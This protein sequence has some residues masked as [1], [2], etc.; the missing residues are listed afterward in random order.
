M[1]ASSVSSSSPNPRKRSYHDADGS[2]GSHTALKGAVGLTEE[3]HD[4]PF[5]PQMQQGKE[6]SLPPT[7]S[8]TSRLTSPAL[9]SN[10]SVFGDAPIP[11]P[12]AAQPIPSTAA[13]KRKLTFTEK[14]AKKVEKELKEK[15]KAEEKARKEAEK[16]TKE[17]ERKRKEGEVKDEKRQKEEER[18]DKKRTKELEKAAREEDKRRKEEE[19]AKKEK[20][21]M[22]LNAFFIK[23]AAPSNA[24]DGTPQAECRNPMDGRRGSTGSLEEMEAAGR[25]RSS[26]ASPQK[27]THTDYER[28]FPPFY[29]QS[30]T[31]LAPHNRFSRDWKALGHALLEIDVHLQSGWTG[32]ERITGKRKA[33]HAYAIEQL[34]IPP[35]KRAKR[36]KEHLTVKE[37]VERMR[38]TANNPID[39]TKLEA[40]SKMPQP[41]GL[42]N[43]I[44]MKHL[45]FA[46]DVRPPYRGT[47]TKLPTRRSASDLARNPFERALPQTNYDYDSEAEWEEPGEGED[48]DS[49]DEEN[50]SE[51]GEDEMEGFLDDEDTGEGLGGAGNKRRHV[52]GDLQP[53]C[54]GLC[55]EDANGICRQERDDEDQYKQ[56]LRVYKLQVILESHHMPLDPLSTAYW[57]DTNASLTISSIDTAS[58][59]FESS[60]MNPPRLPLHVINRTNTVI[61]GHV[62]SPLTL[63]DSEGK[64]VSSTPT[65]AT[66]SKVQKP[67]KRQ[68]APELMPEFKKAIQGSDLTK[69]GLIEILKKQYVVPDRVT[70]WK[71]TDMHVR[72]PKT[73]KDA[74]KD[75]L[76]TIADR[77]GSKEADKRWIIKDGV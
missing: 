25:S 61:N 75:T 44:T 13:K 73:S 12:L 62:T 48:L 67:G 30:H 28:S 66:L 72:F 42:L 41:A 24:T 3:S 52:V 37:I 71:W 49:E 14:E 18:E 35:H 4:P 1:S 40:R 29:V 53:V 58:S 38:G 15:Q 31:T 39:L 46:E 33:F 23:P 8:G 10:G 6:H 68:V 45:Q 34:H 47:Y 74:I 65:C 60:L 16:K 21:Q 50:G 63:L 22:R 57:A 54:S 5:Y 59:K 36:S 19:K 56:R 43:L 27:S 2:D 17:E 55:W 11:S 76:T 26:S 7:S 77:V 51:D 20:S 64:V 70:E 32:V 69:A 9:S